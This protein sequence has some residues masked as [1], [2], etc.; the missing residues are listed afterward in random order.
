MLDFSEVSSCY[1]EAANFESTSWQAGSRKPGAGLSGG[2]CRGICGSKAAAVREGK[3]TALNLTSA[4]RLLSAS[5]SFWGAQTRGA[6]SE[7]SQLCCS[8]ASLLAPTSEK[9]YLLLRRVNVRLYLAPPE[10]APNSSAD[11][12]IRS[13]STP[14]GSSL[15]TSVDA[16]FAGSKGVRT[17]SASITYK[18]SLWVL[19]RCFCLGQTH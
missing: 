16:S 6:T 10:K 3:A 13:S 9:S 18:F 2:S 14:S 19:K 8:W 15:S 5:A 12:D 7:K 17:A 11:I 4:A 1:F